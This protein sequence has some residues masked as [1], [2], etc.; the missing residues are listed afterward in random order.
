MGTHYFWN[1]HA[2]DQV[3]WTSDS[4]TLRSA[5]AGRWIWAALLKGARQLFSAKGNSW[6]GIRLWASATHILRNLKNNTVLKR[7]SGWHITASPFTFNL[8][9]GLNY[10]Q[11]VLDPFL[12]LRVFPW[13]A[14]DC[15]N[16]ALDF[17]SASLFI[18]T[19]PSLLIH[20]MKPKRRIFIEKIVESHRPVQHH[21][22]CF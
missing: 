7:V 1:I 19:L 18:C 9:P 20:T 3:P 8:V 15:L 17:S 13:S 11:W 2:R 16:D 14:L 10:L 21:L 22:N 6:T 12:F 5:S 4:E